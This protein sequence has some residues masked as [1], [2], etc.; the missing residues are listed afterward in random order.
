MI[1]TEITILIN[2]KSDLELI[3]QKVIDISIKTPIYIL[4]YENYNK[5]NFES[6]YEQW[7]LDS[8]I[9]E[10]FPEYEFTKNL[11]SGRKEIRL[12]I[13]RYQSELS[14]DSWGIPLETP[15][16]ETK[17]LIKKNNI[18]SEKLN[19]HIR[20][21]FENNEQHYYIN[22]IDGIIKTTG[23]K[24]FLLLKDIKNKDNKT[25]ID[26]YEDKL[27]K[28]PD[29]A[30][31][32]G[33]GKI[34][35]IANEDFKQYIEIKKKESRELQKI[36][37]K[38]IRNFIN[39]CNNSDIEGVYNSLDEK[40]IYERVLNYQTKLKIIGNKE[41]LEYIKSPNQELCNRNLNIRSSWDFTS[42]SITI[43]VKFYPKIDNEKKLGNILHYSRFV[44]VLKNNRIINIIEEI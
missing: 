17:Y 27:Y 15:L 41:L 5:I 39:S 8:K 23:E 44:F 12:Q 13:S 26:F 29:D 3:I 18:K 35:K 40:V 21:L 31:N 11:E 24:G 16:S 43:G 4:E 22:I 28:T 38:I 36:P 33:Y 37:R 20:V 30:L 10:C 25:S 34:K 2:R 32:S 19:S 6:D 9:L 14:L 1:E 42:T 7:E